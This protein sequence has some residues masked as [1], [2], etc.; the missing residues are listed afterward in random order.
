[1]ALKISMLASANASGMPPLGL[2]ADFQIWAT[3]HSKQYASADAWQRAFSNYKDNERI[4]EELNSDPNDPAEYGHTRFSDMKPEEW[5]A[6]FFGQPMNPE[7][8]QFR[9][10][11]MAPSNVAAPAAF[12]WRDSGAVTDIKDQ[13]SCGS[14]WAE[15]AVGNI[16]SVWYLSHKNSLSAPV[17]LSVQQVIECDAHDDAC[18]GGFP[19]GAFQYVK[20][21]GGIALEDDYKYVIDGHTICLANQTF[22]ETCGDGICDDPPLTSWCDTT[23]SDKKHKYAASITSWNSLPTDEDQIASLLAQNGPVSVAI[24]ASGG[25]MAAILFPWLQF[26]KNGVANPKKCTTN[27]DHAVLLVG[28]GEDNGVKYWTVKNS[29]GTSFGEDGYF[30]LIRGEQKCGV[31]TLASTAVVGTEQFV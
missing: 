5:H 28:F 31:N 22:N 12:D 24:D 11:Q 26:Y 2:S 14:C 17:P 19:S 6:T 1:M 21:S 25:G 9:G 3:Q 29:W 4:I 7:D 8:E 27:L 13:G 10:E 20:E 23:C 15:S 30:R 18:Y 16:E